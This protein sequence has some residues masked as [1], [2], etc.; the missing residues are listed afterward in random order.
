MGWNSWQNGKLLGAMKEN[1]FHALVTADKNLQFQ[2]N[3]DKYQVRIII[4]DCDDT[5]IKSLQPFI[6]LA[7]KE[8]NKENGSLSVLITKE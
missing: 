8:L 5:L 6:P 7:E 3:L 2:Q 1:G 4:L